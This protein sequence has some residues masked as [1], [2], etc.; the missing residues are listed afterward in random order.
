MENLTETIINILEQ[1][2]IPKEELKTNI[3]KLHRMRPYQPSSNTQSVI[4]KFRSHNFKEK[5]WNI[6]KYINEG[7]KLIPSLTKHHS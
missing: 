6:K 7:M 2:G 1:T 5:N 4:L 3:D